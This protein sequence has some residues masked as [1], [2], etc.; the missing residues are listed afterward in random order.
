MEIHAAQKLMDSYRY[1]CIVRVLDHL[2]FR[3]RDGSV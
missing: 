2:L 3:L 1:R